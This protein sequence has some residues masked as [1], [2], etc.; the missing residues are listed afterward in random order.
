METVTPLAFTHQP[1][2]VY[3]QGNAAV[4]LEDEVL[5]LQGSRATDLLFP[6]ALDVGTSVPAD[7]LGLILPDRQVLLVADGLEG[8]VPDLDF[9]VPL[10]PDDELLTPF[11]IFQ[12]DLI[13][14]FE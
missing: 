10:R 3:F 4:G 6:V 7:L 9:L 8:V 2:A 11:L 13:V 14:S 5:G 1:A 12:P